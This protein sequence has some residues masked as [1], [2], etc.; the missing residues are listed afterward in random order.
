LKLEFNRYMTVDSVSVL[1]F[2]GSVQ[3]ALGSVPVEAQTVVGG[4]DI[5]GYSQGKYRGD[6][7]YA[8]QGEYRW[9][10]APPFGMVGFAGLAL[11]VTAGTPLSLDEVLPG[12]GAGF[13]YTMIPEINGN[14][15]VDVAVG[16]EDWGLYFRIAEAF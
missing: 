2:R 1:A 4:K 8:V 11:A 13:R 10:F 16:R 7:V 14:V 12:I 5:R 6:Q 3:A 9:N 15:G